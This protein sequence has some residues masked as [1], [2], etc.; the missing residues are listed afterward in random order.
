[1]GIKI[2][3]SLGLLK[4]LY[5][6]NEIK[7]IDNYLTSLNLLQKDLYLSKDLIKWALEGIMEDEEIK[8]IFTITHLILQ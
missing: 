4:A 2:T 8:K 1:M 5:I 6:N 7:S 3:G